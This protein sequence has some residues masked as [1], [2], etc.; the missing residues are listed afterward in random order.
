VRGARRASAVRGAAARLEI[1]DKIIFT[2][3]AKFEYSAMAD[4]DPRKKPWLFCFIA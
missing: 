2:A 3:Q 4:R 1:L